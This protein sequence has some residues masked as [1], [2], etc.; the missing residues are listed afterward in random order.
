VDSSGAHES[1][2]LSTATIRRLLS[3]GAV[4]STSRVEEQPELE[5]S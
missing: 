2:E 3:A 1:V 4:E 5:M